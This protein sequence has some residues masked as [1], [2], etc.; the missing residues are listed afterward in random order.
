MR[1]VSIAVLAA[2]AFGCKGS[3]PEPRTPTPLEAS[4]K[5]PAAQGDVLA[6]PGENGN[7][8]LTLHMKHLAPPEKM[9]T[10]ATVYIVWVKSTAADGKVQN[11]GALKPDPATLEA[12]FTTMTTLPEFDVM[13][14]AE[15]SAS[16]Q[17]PSGEPLF[18]G[19]TSAK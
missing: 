17:N 11:V 8:K 13:V 9:T 1:F 3:A 18:T 4:S 15:A 16:V 2:V 14:T 12:S 10:G 5:M 19:H 6:E 7:V